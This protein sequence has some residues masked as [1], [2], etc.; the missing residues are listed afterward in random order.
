VCL[1]SLR[2]RMVEVAFVPLCITACRPI[3]PLAAVRLTLVRN[4]YMSI[5]LWFKSGGA[6]V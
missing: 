4:L 6:S 5:K 3:L 1:W 2:A